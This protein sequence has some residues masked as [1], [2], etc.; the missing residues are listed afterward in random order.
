MFPA[1]VWG[2]LTYIWTHW[3]LSPGP[4]ACEAD[5]IPLHHVPH[6]SN[7][8]LSALR[9][10]RR[11][12]R[13]QQHQGAPRRSHLVGDTHWQAANAQR[14]RGYGATAAR[15]TPDQKA[16][17]SNLSALISCFETRSETRLIHDFWCAMCCV[18]QALKE[19]VAAP[20]P[21]ILRTAS[22][23]V[24]RRARER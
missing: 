19:T 20:R 11:S 17:S 9:S 16:G 1:Q 18:R 6:E 3:G 15:L 23:A 12:G 8:Q 10:K 5:V 13:S 22:A 14:H 24:C 21:S 7:S 4:S 2:A